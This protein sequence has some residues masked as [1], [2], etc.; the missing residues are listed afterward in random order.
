[1]SEDEY[2]PETLSG[3]LR[4]VEHRLAKGRDIAHD[5]DMA[6]QAMADLPLAHFVREASAISRLAGF[7][8]YRRHIPRRAWPFGRHQSEWAQLRR[9]PS[10]GWLFLFHSNGYLR[11][12]ALAGLDSAAPGPFLLAGVLY[13]LNDWV[14]EVRTAALACLDRMGPLTSPDIIAATI[15]ALLDRASEWGR[16]ENERMAFDNLLAR[17]DVAAALANQLAVRTT[18]PLARTLRQALRRDA[19]D[20][21]LDRLS[22]SAV[23]PA[24]RVAATVALIDGVARWPAGWMWKW[25]DKSLGLRRRVREIAERPLSVIADRD[26]IIDRA[27]RDSS[28]AVR[29]VALEG[30]MRHAMNAPFAEEIARRLRDD[31]VTRVR[32]RARFILSHTAPQSPGK[33]CA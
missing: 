29:F 2:L 19:L 25:Q 24:V 23:Q 32:A 30:A 16:W 5:A 4:A 28:P 13:R 22:S 3:A 15:I 12:E 20:R 7:Y 8:W 31:P 10:L 26:A 9:T 6:V 27:S 33:Y 21:H 14:P 11:E 17:V 1:M 18:L